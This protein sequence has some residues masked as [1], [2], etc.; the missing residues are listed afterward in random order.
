MRT[1]LQK[2][3]DRA[4][5]DVLNL[6]AQTL[7]ECGVKT[8]P[9]HYVNRVTKRNVSGLIETRMME[10]R[11]KGDDPVEARLALSRR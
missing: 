2:K 10:G 7:I 9:V 8:L 3:C 6:L 5:Q 11:K 1:E 4:A